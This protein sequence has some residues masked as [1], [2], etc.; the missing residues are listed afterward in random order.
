MRWKGRGDTSWE[1]RI[2]QTYYNK[3]GHPHGVH[4]TLSSL[5]KVQN[6]ETWPAR[7][8][9]IACQDHSKAEILHR[10]GLCDKY[11]SQLGASKSNQTGGN[12]ICLA[13]TKQPPIL[14]KQRASTIGRTGS[15]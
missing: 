2:D 14:T 9:I 3:L 6:L 5:I 12:G 7:E 8:K 4:T 15:L 13:E 10:F 1:E 11:S